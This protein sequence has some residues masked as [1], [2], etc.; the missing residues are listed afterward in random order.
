MVHSLF[1]IVDATVA[2]LAARSG[3][4]RVKLAVAFFLELSDEWGDVVAEER[5]VSEDVGPDGARLRSARAY[6]PGAL[7]TVREPRGGFEATARVL[8]CEPLPDGASRL[9]V[10][11][12]GHGPTHLLARR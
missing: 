6:S 3:V 11:F 1:P 2:G 8:E 4:R 9:E 10:D 7:L 12:L 5:A